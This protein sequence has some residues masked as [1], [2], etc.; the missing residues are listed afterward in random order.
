MKKIVF[1]VLSPV[2]LAS[3]FFLCLQL[4]VFNLGISYRDEGFFS[5]NAVRINK[6]EIPYRDFFL[7]T[8]PGTYYINALLFKIFG[9]KLIIGRL[10]YLF[11]CLFIIFLADKIFRLKKEWNYWYLFSLTMALVW[12]GGFAFYNTEAILSAIVAFFFLKKGLDQED[13]LNFVFSGLAAAACFF[14]KQTIGAF[15]GISFLIIIFLEKRTGF[16]SQLKKALIFT[17][18]AAFPVFCYLVY[19]F[20]NG[21]LPSFFYYTAVFAKTVKAHRQPFLTQRL[22]FIPILLLFFKFLFNPKIKTKNKAILIVFALFTFL[23]VYLFFLPSRMHALINHL[24]DPLFYFYSLAFFF[25]LI[26]LAFPFKNKK[27]SRDLKIYSIVSLGIFLALGSSG[28]EIGA[29]KTLTVFFIP[30]FILSD[31][32][33]KMLVSLFIVSYTFFV[34]T[35]PFSAKTKIFGVY[36][37]ISLTESLSLPQTKYIKISPEEKKDLTEVISYVK[38]HTQEK[39]KI[40]CFPYCPMMFVLAERENISYYSMFYFETFLA[41]DQTFVISEIK[42]HG[43]SLIL[44]QKKGFIENEADFEDNRLSKLRDFLFQN[45]HVFLENNNFI[46]LSPQ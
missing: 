45:T 18:A 1:F 16:R 11:L 28:Y 35:N 20:F 37:K 15:T 21:A 38:S 3:L 14:F 12:P 8:T 24:R 36:P 7:T 44:V 6:G 2:F 30:L 23:M 31:I 26:I 17:V 5:Y 29:I 41:K 32:F 46:I 19:L 13:Y 34:F 22:V 43:P 4:P 27:N 10:L 33:P 40:F 42:N 39:D 9:N 25:P